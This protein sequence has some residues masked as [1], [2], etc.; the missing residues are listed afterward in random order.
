MEVCWANDL[1][2]VGVVM[3][4]EEVDEEGLGELL[5]E[6]VVVMEILLGGRVLVVDLMVDFFLEVVVVFDIDVDEL[7]FVFD[8]WESLNIT[9]HVTVDCGFVGWALVGEIVEGLEGVLGGLWV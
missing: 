3:L 8:C 2:G 1:C 7:E 5:E 9:L 4:K 6:V